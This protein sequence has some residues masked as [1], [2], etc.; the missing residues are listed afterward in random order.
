MKFDAVECCVC[1][2]LHKV[3]SKGYFSIE[4]IVFEG[5]IGGTPI[6]G[7]VIIFCGNPS[8]VFGLFMGKQ[9]TQDIF[10][11]MES[12]SVRDKDEK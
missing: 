11:G 7:G 1:G 10:K 8:C 6:L 3:N 5:Y 9:A 12:V 4:G 2:K